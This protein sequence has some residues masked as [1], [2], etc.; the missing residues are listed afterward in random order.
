MS[1]AI[2]KRGKGRSKDIPSS[3]KKKMLP[4]T[5]VDATT[6][7]GGAVET[8]AEPMVIMERK[9]RADKRTNGCVKAKKKDDIKK[10]RI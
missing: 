8:F 7:E 2:L 3:M 5:N 9:L 1:T 6:M 10:I 4:Y